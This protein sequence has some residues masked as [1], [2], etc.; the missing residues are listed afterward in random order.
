MMAIAGIIGTGGAASYI[1]R[2]LGES[3]NEQ[4]AKTLAT[5]G[6]VLSVIIGLVVTILGVI[7][8]KPLVTLLGGL[9]PIRSR[10]HIPMYWFLSSVRYRLWATMLSDN[11]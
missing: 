1:S 7:F 9:V 2:C 6:V 3:R 8:L 10:M 5:G 4:A 11:F